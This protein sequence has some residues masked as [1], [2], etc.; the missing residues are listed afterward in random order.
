MNNYKIF[1]IPG[2]A[3]AILILIDQENYVV[4]LY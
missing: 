4:Y 1:N 3:R 2:G